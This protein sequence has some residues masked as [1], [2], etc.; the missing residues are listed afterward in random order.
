MRGMA[1]NGIAIYSRDAQRSGIRQ[2]FEARMQDFVNTVVLICAAIASLGLGVILAFWVCRAGFALL[3]MQAR[4][5]E[6]GA[7]RAKARTAEI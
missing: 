3:R 2:D 6:S 5:A 4:P 1:W 7:V